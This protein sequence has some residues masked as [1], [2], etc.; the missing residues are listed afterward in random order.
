LIR[1]RNYGRN[2]GYTNDAGEKVPSVSD[3]AKKGVDKSGPLAAWASRVTADY[4]L[5]HW[6]ELAAMP[7][8]ERYWA[9]RN[10]A[11]GARNKAQVS[12]T[13][14]HT[15]I[16]K[17]A[18][19]ERVEYDP[20]IESDVRA[21]LTFLAD[22]DAAPLYSEFSVWSERFGYAGTFDTIQELATGNIGGTTN[23][24]E[25][26]L[27]DWKRANNI[28]PENAL[29]AEGYAQ[30]DWLLTSDDQ[31]IPMPQ[32]DHVGIVHINADLPRG[33]A[34]IPVPGWRRASLFEYFRHAQHMA[35]FAEIGDQ[36]LG[37]PIEPPVW[38]DEEETE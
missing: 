33:Y 30:A 6:D 38:D 28:Y 25:T 13:K 15:L 35:H 12:G 1:R 16:E 34:L 19:G 36:F 37:D 14:F 23:L 21:G 32:I 11:N 27:L 5:D 9:I 3:I 18:A 2:H 31:A 7:L 8:S 29:Q 22:F 10:V 26:W 20:A 17:L 24:Y 4:V